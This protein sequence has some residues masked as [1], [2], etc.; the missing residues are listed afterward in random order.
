[1]AIYIGPHILGLRSEDMAEVFDPN[2]NKA[3]K[4]PLFHS[5]RNIAL[6]N[7]PNVMLEL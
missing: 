5:F 3:F 6:N 2:G 7:L 4:V 1:M